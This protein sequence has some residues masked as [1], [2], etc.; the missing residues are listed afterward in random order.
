MYR[1]LSIAFVIFFVTGCAH[2]PSWHEKSGFIFPR[3]PEQIRRIIAERLEIEKSSNLNSNGALWQEFANLPYN[4]LTTDP[5]YRIKYCYPGGWEIL[6]MSYLLGYLYYVNKNDVLLNNFV[7]DCLHN[8]DLVKVISYFDDFRNSLIHRYNLYGNVKN[9]K[10]SIGYNF[11]VSK[12]YFDFDFMLKNKKLDGVNVNVNDF[13][14]IIKN[15][16]YSHKDFYG[17]LTEKEIVKI[18]NFYNSMK[19]TY[20]VI[21]NIDALIYPDLRID[22]SVMH[23]CYKF[24]TMLYS[25]PKLTDV[26]LLAYGIS[27]EQLG[28]FLE[29]YANVIGEVEVDGKMW[30]A[31]CHSLTS[32]VIKHAAIKAWRRGSYDRFEA[33]YRRLDDRLDK[34]LLL[35]DVMFYAKVDLWKATELE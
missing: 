11:F 25:V 19:N 30:P 29:V 24:S 8:K 7:D 9:T 32:E 28:R 31:R 14:E 18:N 6:T 23:M 21:R 10:N 5:D 20:N 15:F 13:L 35:F 16:E 33:L 4:G 26:A 3:Q 22:K 34:D 2:T 17:N 12:I 1:F 27:D